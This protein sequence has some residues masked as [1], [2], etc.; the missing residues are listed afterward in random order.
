[1]E[2]L[3]TTYDIQIRIVHFPL[4]PDTPEDGLTLEQLFAAR[5]IDIPAVKARMARL[6]SDEG[7]PYGERTMTFNSR[8]AQELAKW[9][10]TQPGGGAIQDALFRAYFVEGLNIAQIDNLVRIAQ[11]LGLDAQEAKDVLESRRFQSAVDTEWQRSRALGITGVPTFMLGDRVVVGAQPY[12]A[13]E[14]L[15]L[16]SGVPRR[17]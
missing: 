8:L 12:D 3:R 16:E 2:R 17:Q 7:L 5:D 4:H 14:H 10:E 15:L 1:M 9:A 13:L 11:Q 6:M